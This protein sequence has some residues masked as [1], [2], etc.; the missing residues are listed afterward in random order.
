M[1][2][3]GGEFNTISHIFSIRYRDR[4]TYDFL[5]TPIAEI[6]QLWP[7]YSGRGRFYKSTHQVKNC[8]WTVLRI[9]C[10]AQKL[11]QAI[12]YESLSILLF[13]S[14]NLNKWQLYFKGL[15]IT[16]KHL[17][18]RPQY[19]MRSRP[20]CLFRLCVQ[21][22]FDLQITT[23]KNQVSKKLKYDHKLFR[24]SAITSFEITKEVAEIIQ[25]DTRILFWCP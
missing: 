21:I 18:D 6:S 24:L 2:V 1:A 14:S 23:H 7:Q 11:K 8:N 5:L 13:Y 20:C 3:C 19:R 16:V 17:E 25:T 22:L 12:P 15:H 9:H 10:A 4:Q